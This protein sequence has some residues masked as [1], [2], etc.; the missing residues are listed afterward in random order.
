MREPSPDAGP[1]FGVHVGPIGNAWLADCR[2]CSLISFKCFFLF[3]FSFFEGTTTKCPG[4]RV[5]M[6]QLI[7]G[8]WLI[9]GLMREEK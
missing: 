5:T 8:M 6:N 9:D 7:L 3:F 1:D 4:D 2:C